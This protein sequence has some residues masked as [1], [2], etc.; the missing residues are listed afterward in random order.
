[1]SRHCF[2]KHGEWPAY[3]KANQKPKWIPWH[4]DWHQMM[5]NP[6][7]VWV[8]VDRD[9]ESVRSDQVIDQDRTASGQSRSEDGE[10][11]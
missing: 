5:L 10:A 6:E 11:E 1:M 9:S 3:L 7:P 8:T 2:A 4:K